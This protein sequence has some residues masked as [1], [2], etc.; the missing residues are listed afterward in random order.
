LPNYNY[1]KIE[2]ENICHLETSISSLKREDF[3]QKIVNSQVLIQEINI[4]KVKN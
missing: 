4:E 2:G 3:V 1:N